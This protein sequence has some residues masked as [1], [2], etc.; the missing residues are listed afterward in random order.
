MS[1][2]TTAGDLLARTTWSADRLAAHQRDRL[3]ALLRHAITASPYYRRVLGPGAPGVPLTELPTLS[4]ATLMERFDEIV[5]NPA[6]RRTDLAA[7]LAGPRAAE[8]YRGHLVLSTSGSTGSPAIFLYTPEQMA[9]GVAGLQRAMALFGVTPG[10]RLVGI[11]APSLMHISRHL[12]AGLSA[13]RTAP[14]PRLSVTTALPEL[15]TALNAS[16]LEAIPTNAS[17]AALLAEEQLAGRLQISPRIVACTSEVL[18]TD[19]SDRIRAAWNV[20]PTS[21]TPP[22]RAPCWPPP[23][24]R[25][26]GC[27]CGKTSCW[28][29]SSTLTGA[30][31][32]RRGR[33]PGAADQPGGPGTAADPLR[34]VRR[35]R[36]GRRRRPPGGRSGGSPRSRAAATTSS[37]CR[38][39]A[40]RWRCTRCTCARYAAFPEV[41]R[42]QIIPTPAR[43]RSGSLPAPTRRPTP[44]TAS[45]QP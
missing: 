15:V 28:W 35:P 23:A 27:T 36:A 44:R 20:E 16:Q 9:I 42:Y 2:A 31:E 21:S 29:R 10:T 30:G 24:Q 6:L 37:P 1:A 14:G 33:A 13:G 38:P 39:A 3:A 19:M 25:R 4:K 32:A 18:T 8:P 12:I 5:T 45:T 17:I 22:R 11:G 40:P 7:H 41:I 26:P 43:C 34:A